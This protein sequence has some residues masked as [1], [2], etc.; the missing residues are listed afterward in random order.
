ML[1]SDKWLG[2]LLAA[3]ETL[4][5][6]TPAYNVGRYSCGFRHLSVR[7]CAGPFI[8]DQIVSGGYLENREA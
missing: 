6:Y 1:C 8:R 3:L 2:E 5:Y 4:Y 7:P